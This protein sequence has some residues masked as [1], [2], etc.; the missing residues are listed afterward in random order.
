VNEFSALKPASAANSPPPRLTVVIVNHE[1]WPDTVRLSESLMA[2][3]E[4]QSGQCQVV[5]VD[6]ASRGPIPRALAVP[7]L[8]VRLLARTHNDGFAAAVNAGW[9]AA[10]SP[11]LLVL[12]PDVE[13]AT[14]FLR[15]VFGELDIHEADP[16]GAPG[17]VGFGLRNPD[18]SPQGSVGVFPS[19]ARTFREQFIPRS[20]RK[21]QAG[22]R[23]RSGRVDWVT[24]ACMLVNTAMIRA[25][26]GMDED[27]FLYY[28]EVAFSRAAQRLGWS[29]KYDASVWVVHRHPLQNRAIS[30]KM[31]IITRHSKLLYFLKHMPRWQFR[32]LCAIVAV[33]AA[34]RSRWSRALRR[35]EDARA[36]RAIAE[37]VRLLRTGAGPRGR[38]VLDFAESAVDPGS[39]RVPHSR[40]TGEFKV[41]GPKG[42]TPPPAVSKSIAR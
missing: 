39:A 3:P 34:I 30:P 20:R 17:I 15:Q 26:G 41:E 2:E 21:Y 7:G 9:R 11:W 35:P 42:R 8:G 29:V 23:I 5:V 33:E 38:D 12:N 31:R 22:W 25:V 16:H 36:W 14:G 13:V 19:L 40:R 18:G 10:R 27:F 1:S 28:E 4:L 24:G 6:N 37:L 32:G